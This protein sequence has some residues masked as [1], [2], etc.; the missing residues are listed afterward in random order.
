MPLTERSPAHRHRRVALAIS[1]FPADQFDQALTTW[2]DLA[3]DWHS[4][5]YRDYTHRLERHLP[6]HTMANADTATT[7]DLWIAPIDI[8]AFQRWCHDTDHDPSTAS[9]RASYAAE[10]TRTGAPEIVPWPPER[11][12]PAGA[13]PA[14]NTRSAADTPPSPTQQRIDRAA[15]QD[16]T[17]LVHAK[18]ARARKCP[19]RNQVVASVSWGVPRAG[20]RRLSA[21]AGAI[22]RIGFARTVTVRMISSR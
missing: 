14:A 16:Q 6:V 8:Q 22:S 1:W 12:A 13:A 3:E 10:R 11:N 19:T 15:P 7:I 5:D 9:A 18:C 21:R 17:G 4:T 20:A 2:P